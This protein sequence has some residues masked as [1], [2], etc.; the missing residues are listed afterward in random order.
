[1]DGKITYMSLKGKDSVSQKEFKDMLKNQNPNLPPNFSLEVNGEF[2]G[3][4]RSIIS[5]ATIIVTDLQCDGPI[6]MKCKINS[7]ILIQFNVDIKPDM[8]IH[9]LITIIT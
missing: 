1:M 9:H 5:D 4:D 7:Q 2:V 3:S 6:F 8:Q